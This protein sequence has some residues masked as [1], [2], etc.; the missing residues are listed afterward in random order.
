MKIWGGVVKVCRGSQRQIMMFSIA[1]SLALYSIP[2]RAEAPDLVPWNPGH[3][4]LKRFVAARAL[5][6][7][8]W[9]TSVED[10]TGATILRRDEVNLLPVTD[11]NPNRLAYVE[12][13]KLESGRYFV[14]TTLEAE[15]GT[16]TRP[17]DKSL[18]QRIEAAT[19]RISPRMT[20]IDDDEFQSSDYH[21]H[22]N[23]Y[24]RTSTNP[25]RS[26]ARTLRGTLYELTNALS[27][28]C[29]GL[30]SNDERRI[31]ELAKRLELD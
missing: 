2:V 31:A 13:K 17:L 3:P 10:E 24:P 16:C 21:V 28:Y 26:D 23:V 29:R 15:R 14:L 1:A 20:E 25:S 4:K 12:L 22:Y 18:G 27:V 19:Q 9:F 7:V 5:L 11:D 30:S 8:S 6:A